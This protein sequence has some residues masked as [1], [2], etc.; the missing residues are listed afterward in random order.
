MGLV[1]ALDPGWDISIQSNTSSSARWREVRQLRSSSLGTIC[2]SDIYQVKWH[3]IV[4]AVRCVV[5][6]PVTKPI[7]LP[8]QLAELQIDGSYQASN[9]DIL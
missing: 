3:Y 8:T 1:P 6:G 5:T 4:C 2:D 9:I 7:Y